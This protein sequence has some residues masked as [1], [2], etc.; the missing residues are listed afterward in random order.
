MAA[1]RQGCAVLQDQ[2]ITPE[3]GL[4]GATAVYISLE[5]GGTCNSFIR[6][7]ITKTS[8][9]DIVGKGRAEGQAK[10]TEKHQLLYFLLLSGMGVILQFLPF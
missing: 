1:T 8:L 2:L 6:N 5:A 3:K 4:P 9:A 10:H 7:K